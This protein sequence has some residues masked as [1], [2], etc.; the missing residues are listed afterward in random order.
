MDG[1]T[2]SS[3]K[4][5]KAGMSRSKIKAMLVVFFIGKASSVMNLY[6]TT[7]SDGKQT[8]VPG[9]FSAFEGCCVEEVVRIMGKPD[10]DATPRQC[11]NTYSDHW[12]LDG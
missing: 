11:D 1:E 8:V 5:K 10:L 9:C 12:T 2:V 7:W 3:S 4:K 6:S